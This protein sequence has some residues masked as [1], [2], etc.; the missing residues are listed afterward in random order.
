MYLYGECLFWNTLEGIDV[1]NVFLSLSASMATRLEWVAMGRLVDC[2]TCR[3]N[4]Q[5]KHFHA[6]KC[7][8]WKSGESSC[9]A[10]PIWSLFLTQQ[11][12]YP[13]RGEIVLSSN[14]LQLVLQVERNQW[15]FFLSY[16]LYCLDTFNNLLCLPPEREELIGETENVEWSDNGRRYQKAPPMSFLCAVSWLF[17]QSVL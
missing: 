15:V 13:V 7:T 3:V 17:G 6:F 9:C 2:A 16:H 12:E 10:D 4:A 8:L 5:S 14:D 11:E 1:W